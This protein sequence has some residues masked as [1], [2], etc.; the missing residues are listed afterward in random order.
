MQGIL[1]EN[2]LYPSNYQAAIAMRDQGK[3]YNE[4]VATKGHGLGDSHL[5]VHGALLD[6]LA[7]LQGAGG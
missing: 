1:I 2:S 6:Y 4:A 7:N 5:C 3:A